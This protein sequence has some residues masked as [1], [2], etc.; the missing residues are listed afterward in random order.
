MIGAESTGQSLELH[1]VAGISGGRTDSYSKWVRFNCCSPLK[2]RS[3]R[4]AFNKQASIAKISKIEVGVAFKL[5]MPNYIS[6]NNVIFIYSYVTFSFFFFR[7]N[8]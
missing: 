2:M 4:G 7:A 3:Q 5:L 8:S 1:L 6:D